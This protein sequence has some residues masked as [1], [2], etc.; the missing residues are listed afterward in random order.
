MGR[1][2]PPAKVTGCCHL[3]HVCVCGGVH[4]GPVWADVG[5][6]GPPPSFPT[7]SS[8]Q[9]QLPFCSEV[10]AVVRTPQEAGA[11]LFSVGRP[12]GQVWNRVSTSPRLRGQCQMQTHLLEPPH[13]L[14][15]VVG[16]MV[17]LQKIR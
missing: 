3:G 9:P 5:R 14:L 11:S 12:P 4:P 7:P 10:P 13:S 15:C 17:S 16:G 2:A 8:P 6:E 1:L